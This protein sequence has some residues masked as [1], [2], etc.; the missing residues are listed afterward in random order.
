MKRLSL[1]KIASV[2]A[3]LKL[4]RSAIVSDD[5]PAVAGTVVAARVLSR[6]ERYNQLEDCTGRLA[7]LFPGDIIAGALG[8]RDALYGYSGRVP[9]SVD[10]GDELQLLNMGGVIGAGAESVP[11]VGE[12]FRLQVLGSVMT[13]PHVGTRRGAPANI[14]SAALPNADLPSSLPPVIALVG[15]CMDAGKT[16]AAGAILGAL[17]RAGLRVAAGKLTGVSLRRDVHWM[18]DHGA[19]RAALFTDFGVVTTDRATALPA[20]RSLLA[21]LA[22]VSPDAIVLE[23]GDGLLGTYGVDALL[24]DGPFRAAIS[25]TVLCA[26]DPVGALGAVD[27]MRHRF[28]LRTDL[29]CGRVTDSPVGQRFCRDTLGVPAWNALRDPSSIMEHL[30]PMLSTEVVT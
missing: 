27:L 13:F 29:I 9:A 10:V 8:H 22:E 20:A 11:G 26:Q 23:M 6:K 25:M 16:T 14:A 7:P 30:A 4:D 5:I 21:H 2:T 18:L 17:R 28:D 19:M 1:D 15:T 3:R 24:S 12:P